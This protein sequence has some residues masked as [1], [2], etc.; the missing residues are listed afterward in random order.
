MIDQAEEEGNPPNQAD[1]IEEEEEEPE[2]DNLRDGSI[3][4]RT[5]WRRPSPRW[6]YPFI[7][8]VSVAL[9]AGMAP[10]SE[11]YI[12]LACLAH[13]PQAPSSSEPGS[14][15]QAMPPFHAQV[16]PRGFSSEIHDTGSW[17]EDNTVSVNTTIPSTSPSKP[18]NDDD[19]SAADKWVV[20]L[21]RDIY[22]YRLH[23]SHP[24]A[25]RAPTSSPSRPLPSGPLPHLST[26][27]DT[28]IEAP[29]DNPAPSSP[30]VTDKTQKSPYHQI[31]PTLCKRD[32]EV[33]AAAARLTMSE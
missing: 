32:P 13:S 7:I 3:S 17:E 11:L 6:V 27:G 29:Q 14:A 12:N 16:V 19:L 28:P 20:K 15:V 25:D 23:H 1:H 33:Q 24:A 31:D 21:Q 18:Q 30:S 5:A 10:R 26:P 9:G 4:R 8:G 22:V 2:W